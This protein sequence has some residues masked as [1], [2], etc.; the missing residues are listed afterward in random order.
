M[1]KSALT[2][3]F[4]PNKS[5][6]RIYVAAFTWLPAVKS[7]C[8]RPAIRPQASQSSDIVCSVCVKVYRAVV[9]KCLWFYAEIGNCATWAWV[10]Q[11]GLAGDTTRSHIWAASPALEC[12]V[13]R[14]ALSEELILIQ[15][16]CSCRGQTLHPWTCA[17]IVEQWDICSWW[18]NFA[19]SLIW[20]NLTNHR[21]CL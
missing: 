15:R 4:W 13:A 14:V 18:F 16:S 12:E 20:C 1:L 10:W 17:A 19:F 9:L 11:A 21:T 2:L 3:S 5:I 6:W 8:H 7:V